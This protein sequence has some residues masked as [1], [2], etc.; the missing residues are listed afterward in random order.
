MTVTEFF[1]TVVLTLG[2][3][4]FSRFLDQDR[5]LHQNFQEKIARCENI[6]EP[7]KPLKG[8]VARK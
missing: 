2:A 1:L 5:E 6:F 4:N 8:R 7:P 3:M